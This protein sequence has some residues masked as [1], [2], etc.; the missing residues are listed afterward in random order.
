[1]PVD[2]SVLSKLVFLISQS[3]HMLL[4]LDETV[5]LITQNKW[6]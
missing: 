5:L 6:L 1:M 2:K 3:K 4:V